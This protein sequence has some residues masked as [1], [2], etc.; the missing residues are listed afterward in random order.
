MNRARPPDEG[1]DTIRIRK[2]FMNKTPRSIRAAA[3]RRLDIQ[4]LASEYRLVHGI[5][6]EKQLPCGTVRAT[7]IPAILQKDFGEKG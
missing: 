4:D 3:L 5:R 1:F 7:M 6:I 2:K